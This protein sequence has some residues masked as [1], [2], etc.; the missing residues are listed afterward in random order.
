[1]ISL[2]W[3]DN[4]ATESGYKIE[5]CAGVACTAFAE[6]AQVAANTTTFTDATLSPST[7][8]SY[9]VRA[10]DAATNSAYSSAASTTTFARPAP[11]AP[12]NLAA[13]ATSSNQVN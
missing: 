7:S 9:R 5:R 10:F 12:T 11:S 3:L 6:V 13:T 8:Y 2:T 1:M 4:A